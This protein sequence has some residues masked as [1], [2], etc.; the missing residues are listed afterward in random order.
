MASKEEWTTI[1]IKKWVR[2]QLA[3]FKVHKNESFNDVVIRLM[4]EAEEK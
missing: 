1:R 3:K 2:E 4:G